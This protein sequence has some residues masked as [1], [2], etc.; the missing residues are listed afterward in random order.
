MLVCEPTIPL[1]PA[2]LGQVFGAETITHY[3]I[4]VSLFSD[5]CEESGGALSNL[6]A[7]ASKHIGAFDKVLHVLCPLLYGKNTGQKAFT[8]CDW[9]MNQRTGHPFAHSALSMFTVS[10]SAQQQ[11]LPVLPFSQSDL[12]WKRHHRMFLYQNEFSCLQ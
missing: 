2:C 12:C 8:C 9:T 7:K 6:V 10:T 1:A 3:Q 5:G 11:R 4:M